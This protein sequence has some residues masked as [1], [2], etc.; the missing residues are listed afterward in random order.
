MADTKIS[1]LPAASAAASANELAINEAGT[2]KKLTVDQVAQY[3]VKRIAGSSGAA[4]A[5]TTWQN[6][7]ADSA[8]QTSVTT[9]SVVMTTTGLGAG[10]WAF[11]YTLIYQ[12]AATGT[13]L[14]IFVNHT[15]TTGQFAARWTQTDTSATASTAVG[16]T[17]NTTAAGGVLSSKTESVIN[18][19]TAAGI[20]VGVVSANTDVMAVL[21]GLVIVTVSGD[22]QLK[23]RTEVDTS[24]VR[25]MADSCL[26]LI[27]V[28]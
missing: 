20:S 24:A 3:L 18:T 21:E 5:Y 15:G 6:L 2:S 9:P 11:K 12:T 23:I 19:I 4:G 8:D 26:E 27:K 13:G 14:A 22:L 16:A 10:T 17:V 1:A 7:T 28:E 25:I